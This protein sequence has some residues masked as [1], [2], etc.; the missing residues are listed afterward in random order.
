MWDGQL[1]TY[2]YGSLEANFR[3]NPELFLSAPEPV[4]TASGPRYFFDTV[5]KLTKL[6]LMLNKP[7][8]I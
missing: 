6:V 2:L 8:P 3:Q 5:K 1:S 7:V 4:Y